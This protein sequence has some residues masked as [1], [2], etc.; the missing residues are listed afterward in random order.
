MGVAQEVEKVAEP[1]LAAAGIELVDVEYQSE[2][3]GWILR[4]Y[5]D[6]PGGFSLTDCEEWNDRLGEVVEQSGLIS[7]AYSLEISSPG[8]N[9]PLKKAEDFRRFTGVEAVIKLYAARNGQKNFHGGIVGV[10][11]NEL[12]L[13][14]RTSGL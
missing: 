5:L 7:H 4:F 14:D 11:G 2:P 13:Q 6:K 8:L 3:N 10:E 12:R 9:R 1:V